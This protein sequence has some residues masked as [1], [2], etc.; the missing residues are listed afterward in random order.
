MWFD[1]AGAQPLDF[2]DLEALKPWELREEDVHKKSFAASLQETKG[3]VW[4]TG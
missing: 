2:K 4:E 3:G 1:P